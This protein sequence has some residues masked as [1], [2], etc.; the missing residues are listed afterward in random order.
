MWRFIVSFNLSLLLLSNSRPICK[1]TN[2][3]SISTLHRCRR[4]WWFFFII[5]ILIAT[6]KKREKQSN[7]V[8]C[9]VF[10][11]LHNSRIYLY[12]CLHNS[13]C[14]C[15]CV[16]CTN[17]QE[18]KVFTFAEHHHKFTGRTVELNFRSNEYAADDRAHIMFMKKDICSHK[19][20]R[21][22]K[23]AHNNKY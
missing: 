20:A 11:S 1:Q 22:N 18:K 16:I 8:F 21:V 4:H 19:R 6:N 23:C 10:T 13:A 12:I 14:V 5:T 9:C 17:R 7:T 15:V 2:W 3:F